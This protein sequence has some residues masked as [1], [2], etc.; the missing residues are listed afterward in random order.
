MKDK[1]TIERIIKSQRNFFSCFALFVAG[2]LTI[3]KKK[4]WDTIEQRT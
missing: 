4:K 3:K 1:Q 2:I